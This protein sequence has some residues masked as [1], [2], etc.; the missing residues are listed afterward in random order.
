M[1]VNHYFE[2]VVWIRVVHA[3]NRRS[4]SRCSCSCMEHY[5]H[6][7]ATKPDLKLNMCVSIRRWNSLPPLFPIRLSSAYM[8]FWYQLRLI[9]GFLYIQASITRFYVHASFNP[10]LLF[11]SL[12][13]PSRKKNS[14][15]VLNSGISISSLKIPRQKHS[16]LGM[17]LCHST[18]T[19]RV[20]RPEPKRQPQSLHSVLCRTW[21]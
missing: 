4:G 18:R 1:Y 8:D 17:S 16:D 9:A 21:W 3:V 11:Y 20:R 14:I 15:S 2:W 10:T 12:K 19:L 6:W 7:A 5:Y 13:Q